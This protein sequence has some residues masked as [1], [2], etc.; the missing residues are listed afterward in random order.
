[1]PRAVV[2]D[3]ILLRMRQ[4]V[5]RRSLLKIFPILGFAL[6]LAIHAAPAEARAKHHSAEKKTEA[7][8]P[9]VLANIHVL[10][11]RPAPFALDAKAAMIVDADT[12]ALLYA[13]NEHV[14]MQP[15]SLAKIM[16][17]YLTL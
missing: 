5:R 13:Y 10:G 16:T 2:S 17:F 15:A 14:K 7:R 4:G 8:P 1:M 12:G 3:A 9:A 11:G 6:A